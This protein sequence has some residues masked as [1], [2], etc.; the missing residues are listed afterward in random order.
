MSRPGWEN[1]SHLNGIVFAPTLRCDGSILENEGYDEDT[2]IFL[3]LGGYE[4]EKIPENPTKEE[5]EA[6]LE[7]IDDML[8]DFPFENDA[9]KSVTISAILTALIRKSI[10]TA[11]LHAFSAPKMA[12]GKS[13]LAELVSLT[14]T[15]KELTTISQA[16]NEGEEGKRIMAVLQDGDPVVCVDNVERPLGSSTLCIVLTSREYTGRILGETRKATYPTNIIF[17]A[18][19]N[20]LVFV[21]D[22]STRVLLCNLD[23]KV[24]KPEERKFDR[25]IKSYVLKNRGKIIRAGLTILR[26]YAIAGWPKQEIQPF[27]RFEEWSDWVRSSLVWLGCADPNESR[28]EIEN[29]DPI[30]ISIE[31]T[32]RALHDYFGT[33]TFTTN[34]IM[35]SLQNPNDKK[36]DELREALSELC[37]DNKERYLNPRVLGHKFAS[38]KGRFENGLKIEQFGKVGGKVVWKIA[39]LIPQKNN[40]NF[41]QCDI[42]TDIV[43]IVKS[44]SCSYSNAYLQKIEED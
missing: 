26:A 3:F 30:R 7:V 2:G 16:E 5:A 24:E 29:A 10:S 43:K 1:I 31:N 21:G 8:K 39:E 28:K 42:K 44:H 34:K 17:L 11:P 27:G 13:L 14:T 36:T 9:S 6:A 37:V 22:L 32:L 20:N 23:P 33:K 4:F 41:E 38:I 40:T 19:G 12:S 25:D 15:G 18:T 35:E